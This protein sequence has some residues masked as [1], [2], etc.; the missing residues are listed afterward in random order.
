MR[1]AAAILILATLFFLQTHPNHVQAI[2]WEQHLFVA[3]GLGEIDGHVLTNSKE[4]FI[5]NYENGHRLFEADLTYTTDGVLV[6]RHNVFEVINGVNT[7]INVSYDHF[8]SNLLYEKYTALDVKELLELLVDYEDAYL[9]T[10]TKFTDAATVG[11]QFNM[12]VY[13]AKRIDPSL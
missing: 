7:E 9:I 12:L 10:D 6:A 5:Q 8:Q 13:L 1:Q 11:K 4:A 2:E 3:H